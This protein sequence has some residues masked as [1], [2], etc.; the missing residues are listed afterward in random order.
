MTFRRERRSEWIEL[1]D[2]SEMNGGE[3]E[4]EGTTLTRGGEPGKEETKKGRDNQARSSQVKG[5][6][7][8]DQRHPAAADAR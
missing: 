3:R 8:R 7:T 6:E 2:G 1:I 5:Q 4:R